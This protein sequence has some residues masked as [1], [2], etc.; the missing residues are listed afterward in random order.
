MEKTKNVWEQ[1]RDDIKA[2]LEKSDNY[3][4]NMAIKELKKTDS[5]TSVSY[6]TFNTL[7]CANRKLGYDYKDCMFFIDFLKY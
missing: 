7:V 5:Y 1:L 3:L 6:G 4:D 2:G